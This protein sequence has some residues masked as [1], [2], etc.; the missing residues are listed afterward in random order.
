MELWQEVQAALKEGQQHRAKAHAKHGTL[1][2][3]K[4]YAPSG[5]VYTPTYTT[6]G[7]GKA[8]EECSAV[9]LESSTG[10]CP[11]EILA[12]EPSVR[13]GGGDHHRVGAA[14]WHESHLCF[15]HCESNVSYTGDSLRH[16][17]R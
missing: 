2:A 13:N 5:G 11:G 15:A 12:V 8:A 16:P 14:G 1:L 4:C 3:G 17:H 9:T 6:R 10:E 7:N